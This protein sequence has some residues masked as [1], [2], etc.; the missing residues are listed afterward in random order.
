MTIPEPDVLYEDNHL[1]A[2]CKPAGVLTMGDQTGDVT[3]VDRHDE[4]TT[5][6]FD[7]GVRMRRAL[8]VIDRL[9][10]KSL[11]PAPHG[12]LEP[13]EELPSGR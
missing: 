9:T 3:M 1:L 2:V 13:I 8:S 10:S 12:S 11:Y 4:F 7:S 5:W 6:F